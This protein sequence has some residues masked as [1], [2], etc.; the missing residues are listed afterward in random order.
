MSTGTIDGSNGELDVTI[1]GKSAHAGLYHLGIDSIMIASQIICQYQSI[2]SRVIAPVESCVIN[3]GEIQGGTVRNIVADQTTFKGTVRTY[4]ETV[5]KKLQIRWRQLIMGW[6]KPM[7]VPLNL[8][9][10]QCIHR[11]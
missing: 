7:A 11:F 8:V 5:F 2:I 4:S 9:A 3:I 1:T 10:R 6:S